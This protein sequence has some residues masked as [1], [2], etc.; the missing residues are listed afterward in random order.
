MVKNDTDKL[1]KLQIRKSELLSVL[2]S[3]EDEINSILT[4]GY[5]KSRTYK[6]STAF[7]LDSNVSNNEIKQIEKLNN[8]ERVTYAPAAKVVLD[9]SVPL[10]NADDIW[11]KNKLPAYISKWS[12]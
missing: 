4:T 12:L 2:D 1:N 10:I 7:F 9:E 11:N 8:I 3:T 5:I 6:G